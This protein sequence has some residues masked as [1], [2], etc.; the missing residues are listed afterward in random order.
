MKLLILANAT[1]VVVADE[2]VV[3]DSE[4]MIK[5]KMNRK[6]DYLTSVFPCLE[7]MNCRKVEADGNRYYFRIENVTFHS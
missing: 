4:E 5:K 3:G 6:F 2:P 7:N 1:D